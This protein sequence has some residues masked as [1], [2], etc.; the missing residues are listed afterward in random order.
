MDIVRSPDGSITF[1]TMVSVTVPAGTLMQ[2]ALQKTG[3][4]LGLAAAVFP[5]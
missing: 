2:E 1:Q 4:I 3:A 5:T